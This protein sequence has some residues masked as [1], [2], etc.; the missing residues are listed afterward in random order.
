M[1]L[2]RMGYYSGFVLYPLM[3]AAAPVVVMGDATNGERLGW[4]AMC[5]AGVGLWTLTEYVIHRY[6]LHHVPM[7]KTMHEVHHDEQMALVGT[8]FWMSLLFFAFFSFLPGMLLFVLNNA[9]VSEKSSL[10]RF[11]QNATLPDLSM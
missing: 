3:V 8:P 10:S 5:L 7:F 6:V 1:R 11:S 9:S 4:V 2:G